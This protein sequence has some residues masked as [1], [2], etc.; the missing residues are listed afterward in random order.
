[1]VFDERLG[2]YY[3]VNKQFN[4]ALSYKSVYE[5]IVV[6]NEVGHFVASFPADSAFHGCSKVYSIFGS[7]KLRGKVEKYL[8]QGF[9][10]LANYLH[11][12]LI[13]VSYQSQ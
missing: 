8:Y 12:A 3:G 6:V 4:T 1:M 10:I 9:K 5:D 11:G 7:A 13:K 2:D